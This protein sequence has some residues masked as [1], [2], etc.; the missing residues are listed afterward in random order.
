MNTS[1]CFLD[2]YYK[3]WEIPVVA[4]YLDKDLSFLIWKI[5]AISIKLQIIQYIKREFYVVAISSR[6]QY[7]YIQWRNEFS[8]CCERLDSWESIEPI[9]S[10]ERYIYF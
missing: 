2:Y 7:I 4:T 9:K 5:L 10:R 3:L 8:S 1:K 6:R